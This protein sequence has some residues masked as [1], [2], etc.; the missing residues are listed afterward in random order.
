MSSHSA[1]DEDRKDG[2][3]VYSDPLIG[4]AVASIILLLVFAG[5]IA[6]S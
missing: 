1:N 6:A 2:F 5:L 4:M 3:S